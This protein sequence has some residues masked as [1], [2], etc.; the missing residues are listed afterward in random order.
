MKPAKQA[1]AYS[2][3]WSEALR[4]QPQD[5]FKEEASARETGGSATIPYAAACFAGSFLC[6][7]IPGVSLAKPRSTPGYMR[8]P[9]SQ[10]D[11]QYQ[12]DCFWRFQKK[13]PASLLCGVSSS[14]SA[15]TIGD[16]S[17][18][19]TGHLCAISRR[20]A[21]CSSES[22]PVTVTERSMR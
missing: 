18:L 13:S 5:P 1:T 15:M 8:L 10:T 21:R 2:L 6:F 17:V 4:A 7:S 19:W 16:V 9:A 11:Q 3:G 14:I 12:V 22:C 20:R